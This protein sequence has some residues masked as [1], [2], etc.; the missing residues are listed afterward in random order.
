MS[1]CGLGNTA[2]I[3]AINEEDVVRVKRMIEADAD[4]RNETLFCMRSGIKLKSD[5]TIALYN[6]CNE[7]YQFMRDR[8]YFDS[9][10][11]SRTSW[12]FMELPEYVYPEGEEV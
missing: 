5:Y 3:I 4:L 7:A 1:A 8:G 10:Y 9:K 6:E 12:A 11:D 2:S